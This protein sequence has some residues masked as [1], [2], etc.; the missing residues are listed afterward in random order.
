MLIYKIE[1]FDGR[2]YIGQTT[3]SLSKRIQAYKRDVSTYLNGKYKHRSKIIP[4]LAKYGFDN[5]RFYQIDNAS[6]QNELD[7]KEKFWVA[8]YNSTIQGIGFNIQA[9]GFGVGKHTDETKKLMSEKK[10]GK[11]AH[12][13]GKPG[14]SGEQVGN[15]ALTQKQA[16]QIREEY[17]AGKSSNKLAKQYGVTKPTILNVLNGKTY[18]ATGSVINHSK[19]WFIYLIQSLKDGSIYT[20]ITLNV[21]DRLKTHNEG[22]GARYTRSRKPFVILKFFTRP[23]KGEALKLEYQIKQMSKQEKL[24]YNE[25]Q[26]ENLPETSGS[27]D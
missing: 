19:P 7:A 5:F 18:N 1:L 14:L 13:K 23:T 10:K 12:N 27:N 20:G 11:P 9:G 22:R 2:M 26:E 6:L 24:E 3:T 21:E 17:K 16:D 8:I 15:A 25:P 4:A